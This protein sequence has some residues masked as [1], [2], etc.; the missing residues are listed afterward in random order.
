MGCRVYTEACVAGGIPLLHPLH[1]CFTG[2]TIVGVGGIINGTTNYI[3]TAM[4]QAGQDY[5]QALQDAQ[6]LGYAEADPSAD[7]D[8]LDALYKTVILA[9]EALGVEIPWQDISCSGITSIRALDMAAAKRLQCQIKLIGSVQRQGDGVS[10]SVEPMLIPETQILAGVQG[11]QN[12]VLVQGDAVGEVFFAGPGAGRLPTGSA[13]VS[14]LVRVVRS[15]YAANTQPVP[16]GAL[17]DSRSGEYYLRWTS[18]QAEPEEELAEMLKPYG[19]R[20]L[21]MWEDSGDA[22]IQC[23]RVNGLTRMMKNELIAAYRATE[24]AGDEIL[25]MRLGL[26]LTD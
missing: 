18:R 14:D 11:V 2:N 3:L 26:Q 23:A 22:Q 4:A 19:A 10:A 1:V 8:G 7:V 20:C 13:V 6:E 24:S 15:H 16:K 17:Q 12:G 5:G 9:R 25:A 21:E